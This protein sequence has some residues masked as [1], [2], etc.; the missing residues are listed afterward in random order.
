M[1]VNKRSTACEIYQ[2]KMFAS[3]VYLYI[4]ELDGVFSLML[5]PRNLKHGPLVLNFPVFIFS[6][7][8]ISK[9]VENKVNLAPSLKL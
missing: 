1:F 9:L 7:K 6:K 3:Y 2:Q 8:L 4:L 5:P